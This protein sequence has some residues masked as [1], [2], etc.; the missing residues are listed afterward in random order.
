MLPSASIDSIIERV[1][2]GVHNGELKTGSID[3]KLMDEIH[4]M[5]KDS[6]SGYGKSLGEVDYNTPDY[7]TISSLRNNIRAFS[8]A[9]TY[10]QLKAMNELLVDDDGNVRSYQ[11]FKDKALQVHADYNRNYLATEYNTAV[12]QAQM[13]S[14]WNDFQQNDAVPNI[15][16]RTA[17]DERVRDLHAGYEGFTKPK[18]WSGWG[19]FWP[20]FDWACRC[21]AEESEGD[22]ITQEDPDTKS[23]PPMFKNNSGVSGMAF[24]NKHPYFKDVTG[25]MTELDAVTNYGMKTVQQIYAD[26]TKLSK[27]VREDFTTAWKK[28]MEVNQYRTQDAVLLRDSLEGKQLVKR[29]IVESSGYVN[30]LSRVLAN[31]SEVWLGADNTLTFI[32]YLDEL[33]LVVKT[34]KKG[35]VQSYET[36]TNSSTLAALRKGVLM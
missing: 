13:A 34:N 27:A 16:I 15:T 24:T 6:L 23:I 22:D 35:V 25:K 17:G 12:G 20:P 7:N 33:A 2:K 30:Y 32:K 36:I 19:T 5:M 28:L 9:K 26:P 18:D 4:E 3:R 14:K 29:A 11:D 21:T 10:S 31:P 8:G 1:M